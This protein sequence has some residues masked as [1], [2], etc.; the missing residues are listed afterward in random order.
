MRRHARDLRRAE[1]KGREIYQG[2]YERVLRLQRGLCI[3][4]RQLVFVEQGE[5]R[6]NLTDA[7]HQ[8]LITIAS[9]DA[10]TNQSATYH[11]W[12]DDLYKQA[13][14]IVDAAKPARD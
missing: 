9:R 13:K 10:A 6:K 5:E 14:Q 1:S 8:L 2:T 4:F 11:K 3:G 12:A 7:L